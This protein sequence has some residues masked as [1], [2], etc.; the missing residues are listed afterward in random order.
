MERIRILIADDNERFRQL[1]RQYIENESDMEIVGEADTGQKTLLQ[2]KRLKPD[3]LLL[4][5]GM[6]EMTGVETLDLV[7]TLLGDTKIIML[8]VFDMNEYKHAADEYGASG[9][10]VK[11]DVVYTLL[12]TIRKVMMNS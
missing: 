4:D 12:P 10:I 5:V 6:P 3:L 8:T 11:K 1:L 7:N 2:S 9:Y